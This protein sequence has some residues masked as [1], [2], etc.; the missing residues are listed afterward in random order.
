MLEVISNETMRFF[1]AKT[2]KDGISSKELMLRAAKGLI[3]NLGDLTKKKLA[4]VC[5]PGNNGGD[6][7]AVAY[8]LS[9]KSDVIIEVFS[10]SDKLST[11]GRYYLEQ[12]H[13][14]NVNI[15]TDNTNPSQKLVDYDIILDCIFGTGFHGEIISPYKE[16]IEAINNSNAYIVS[17]D[18]SSGLNGTNGLCNQ[19][20]KADR[21]VAIGSLKQ[22]YYLNSGKDY[23]KDIKCCDIGIKIESEI[24]YLIESGDI[25][26]LF[27]PRNNDSNK[28]AYGYIGL[29]GGSKKYCGAAKLSNIAANLV[30]L[31][32]ASYRSGSGV[33]KLIVPDIISPNIRNYILESTCVE[34]PSDEDGYLS[35]D[36]DAIKDAI[37][38][39]KALGLG[40]G[41]GKGVEYP[42]ILKYILS[43]FNNPIVIDADGLNLLSEGDLTALLSTNGKLVLTPHLKEFSRLCGLS[44]NEIKSDIINIAKNFAKE[45]KIILLLKGPT[46]IITDGK[47]VYLCNRGCAGMATAGSGDVLTG[48]LTALLGYNEFSA[49]TVAAAS[50]LNGL[51]GEI[52]QKTLNDISMTAGDT[53]NSI[54]YA[55]N[56]IRRNEL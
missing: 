33:V 48:I 14:N 42:E 45:Y 6:G 30:N 44:L 49:L 55:I 1:D 16:W 39:L 21:I 35:Y 17:A 22:G 47:I 37:K 52:A 46:T 8:L 2:I 50:Y 28:G 32:M 19:A 31:S 3:S 9:D 5:G 53:V 4:I 29:I 7:Y 38:G 26:H 18:I 41:W 25:A 15:N 12:C 36:E 34:L 23:C 56:E 43:N 11:D 40:M 24:N 27:I 54:G 10:L 13:K 51:S 20:I